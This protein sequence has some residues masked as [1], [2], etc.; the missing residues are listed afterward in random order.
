[1]SFSFLHPALLWGLLAAAIPLVIHLFFRRRPKPTPFPAIAFIL[2]AR[3]ETQRR[4]RLR[5]ILLFSA[6]T[7]LLAAV[8]LAVA[9]PR[10][11]RPGEAAAAVTQGPRATAIVL[12]VSASMGYR[13]R[14]GDKTLFERA[15]ED[16]MDTLRDLLS[17]EPA[18]VVV[19]GPDTPA[20]EA[21]SFDRAAVR[22]ALE[23]A[24]LSSGHA[25][26]T[27]CTGAALRALT[28]SA[29]QASLPKRLVVATDLTAAGWRLDA[30]APVLDGPEGPVRPEVTLLDA[31][32]GA[33]LPNV[34]VGDLSVDPDPAVGPRGYRIG[35][36][37]ANHGPEPLTDVSV[38]LKVALGADPASE[39]KDA[40]TAIRAFADVPAGSAVK[41]TLSHAF[42]Q[43]GPIALQ[44]EL[45]EDA[46]PID[47]ARA[48]T[49]TVP[50]EVSALVV[51]GAPSPVKYRDEAYFVESALASTA[52]PI[53]TT[54]I[55][56]EALPAQDLG[57]FDVVFLLN[58]RSVGA[59]LGELQRFVEEGGGL[60]ISLGD[61]VDP[62]S[63]AKE[64]GPLLPAPLHLVK[65]AAERGA[66]GSEARAA[67]FAEI[68]WAHPAF[69]IFTGDAR[70][71]LLGVRTFRYVLT[72]P[73]DSSKGDA[74]RVLAA[75]DDGAPALVEA[76]RGEG[77]VL[78]FTSTSDRDWTD[79]P[80]R[81]S[82]LPAMQRFA[83][84]LAGGL[85]ERR[86]PPTVVGA[87]R[88]LR[89]EGGD[90]VVALVDP[91]GRERRGAELE[92]VLGDKGGDDEAPTFT[93]RVPGL[94]SVKVVGRTGERLEPKLAFAVWP[95]PRESDTRR[96]E[97]SELTAWFGGESHARVEGDAG[98]AGGER[99]IP[100]WSILLVLGVVAFFLEGLLLT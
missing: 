94:W 31:A 42:A 6:R 93:P 30:P 41:K 28:A 62:E 78:L 47:D 97:P 84:Y 76:R 52:S 98:A 79:W 15:K 75:F 90:R 19:C 18:T 40:K 46:L 5:K 60:F 7:L 26:L 57:G 50:R 1:M 55:D 96:L 49:L 80:I 39:L 72:R 23:T 58:V 68:A 32:R 74:P 64:L 71:G 48:L 8:A 36:A 13:L 86:E 100:L 66:P 21:P 16:A 17:E 54:V 10:A 3:K 67:R 14:P 95:D 61:Q 43:G 33:K 51:N 73:V 12:D 83:T 85:E 87:P 25:D 35:A 24:E 53:R 2:R 91:A 11:E 56:A 29:A 22:R 59:K 81:T 44:V 38:Q 20:A 99:S 37:L 69:A 92:A 9:R 45:P 88:S 63:S 4:L 82:F 34:A 70:E 77:R 65:T 89:A 27:A